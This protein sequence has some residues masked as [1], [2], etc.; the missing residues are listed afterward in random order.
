MVARDIFDEVA[1]ENDIFSQEIST[2]ESSIETIKDQLSTLLEKYDQKERRSQNG[3]ITSEITA[4]VKSEVSKI[5]PVQNII[6]RTI[7][8]KIYEPVHVEPK[9]VAS[10]P[11]IIKEIRVEVQKQDFKKYVEEKTLEELRSQVKALT[12]QLSIMRETLPFMGGSG[13]IGLPN[14]DGNAGK[15]LQVVNGQWKPVAVVSGGGSS[16]DQYTT[17]N[18]TTTRTLD[19]TT[20]SVD[21]LYNVLAS[22]I[23][24]LQ[25]AGIIQ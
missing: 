8:K 13:V 21:A 10:P 15:T 9:I 7:E 14:P 17:S 25:G 12:D 18:V 22:L 20:S 2:E 3:K 16:S 23:V 11:Q 6:E 19:P 24:S 1:E 5:K 4:L